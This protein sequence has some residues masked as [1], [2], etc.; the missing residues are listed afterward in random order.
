MLAIL[1]QHILTIVLL[2]LVVVVN[3]LL[4]TIYKLNFII[5]KL[6]KKNSVPM[7]QCYLQSQASTGV[8]TYLLLVRG[9]GQL[10][11]RKLMT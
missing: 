8:G 11:F 7:V 4:C 6:Y 10:Y 5:G 1:L 3:L 2:L 9:E